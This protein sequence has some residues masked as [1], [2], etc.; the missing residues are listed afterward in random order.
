MLV[1][2]LPMMGLMFDSTLLFIIKSRLQASVDGAALAGAAGWPGAR[3][4]RL[5]SRRPRLLPSMRYT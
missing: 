2:A 1:L 5:R 4:G 3:T